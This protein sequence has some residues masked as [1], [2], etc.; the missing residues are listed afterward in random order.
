MTEIMYERASL[1][2][3]L[4]P[5]LIV[6]QGEGF[7]DAIIT[8]LLLNGDAQAIAAIDVIHRLDQLAEGLWRTSRALRIE[9]RAG[10][11]SEP[12]ALVLLRAV[13]ESSAMGG[14]DAIRGQPAT[15]HRG[16]PDSCEVKRAYAYVRALDEAKL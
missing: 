11:M 15:E 14:G 4:R 16:C 7:L 13:L 9:R 1:E 12:N 10:E 6:H 3:V 5:E 8:E 2:R